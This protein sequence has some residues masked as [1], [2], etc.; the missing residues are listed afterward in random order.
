MLRTGHSGSGRAEPPPLEQHVD[1]SK[2]RPADFLSFTLH[3]Q[4]VDLVVRGDP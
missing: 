3:L 2:V 1:L 4:G